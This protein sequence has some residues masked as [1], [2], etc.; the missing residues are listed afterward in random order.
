MYDVGM[1]KLRGSA[2]RKRT[3]GGILNRLRSNDLSGDF[4]WR[5]NSSR[6]AELSFLRAQFSISSATANISRTHLTESPFLSIRRNATA[7]NIF[8][9]VLKKSERELTIIATRLEKLGVDLDTSSKSARKPNFEYCSG[10]PRKETPTENTKSNCYN[11]RSD[12]IDLNMTDSQVKDAFDDIVASF[13]D[14]VEDSFMHQTGASSV[15]EENDRKA[16]SMDAGIEVFLAPLSQ[17]RKNATAT[18]NAPTER[19]VSERI[20]FIPEPMGLYIQN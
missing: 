17:E 1:L 15:D 5:C 13:K 6:E 9:H 11:D 12:R 18:A 2:G 7:N 3:I 8:S 19:I 14:D 20:K 10:S 4:V 16:A